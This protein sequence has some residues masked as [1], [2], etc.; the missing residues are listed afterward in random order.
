ML[1]GQL[2]RQHDGVVV[3]VLLCKGAVRLEPARYKA[4]V[5]FRD[6]DCVAEA[7]AVA[8]LV[9]EDGVP[10]SREEVVE[11]LQGVDVGVEVDAAGGEEG[12]EAEDVG[13]VGDVPGGV[14]ALL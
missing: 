3:P 10:G 14:H 13:D 11:G 8:A 2:L 6:D 12:L 4:G 7:V 5:W 1:H 9:A